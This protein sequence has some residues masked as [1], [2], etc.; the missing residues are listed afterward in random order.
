MYENMDVK[1]ICLD[2]LIDF[3]NFC[4][5]E[6]LKYSL[7]YGTAIGAVRHNGFI[8]WDDDIDV[9]M[10]RKDYEIFKERYKNRKYALLSECTKKYYYPYSKL[11][12]SKYPVKEFARKEENMAIWID[13]FP[14]DVI[15]N[16]QW[17]IRLLRTLK[18]LFWIKG[19]C[20]EN[21]S[22]KV[23]YKLMRFFSNFLSFKSMNKIY[24][25]VILSQNKKNEKRY[26]CAAFPYEEKELF[27][28]NIFEE[29]IECSFENHNFLLIKNYDK[30]LTQLYGEY[31]VLPPVEK[32]K[33]HHM[34]NLI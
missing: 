8:P 10:P 6:N 7:A 25:N 28:E 11:I 21:D 18:H 13:I 16:C 22:T 9:I 24:K 15:D 29:I 20:K 4:K 19:T 17:K 34:Y 32:Q 3:D 23:K 14:I 12:D 2:I 5:K 26:V 1:K 30:Y 33:A 27:K 31:M